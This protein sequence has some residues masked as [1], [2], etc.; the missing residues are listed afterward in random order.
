MEEI[1][2]HFADV[3]T[4][5]TCSAY[6]YG[7]DTEAGSQDWEPQLP[8]RILVNFFAFIFL[9]LF[10]FGAYIFIKYLVIRP[11]AKRVSMIIF[12][13][14]TLINLGLSLTIIIVLNW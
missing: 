7:S 6:I 4:D 2:L 8:T 5:K 14:L 13:V 12:Y 3:F 10:C 11:Q 1:N 9:A